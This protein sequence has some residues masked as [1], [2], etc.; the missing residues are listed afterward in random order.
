MAD[1]NDTVVEN[2][3]DKNIV[4]FEF[5]IDEEPVKLSDTLAR[6]RGRIFYKGAN[7]NRSFITEEFANKLLETV[8]YA[9]VKGIY[10]AEN[11]DYTDHGEENCEGRAY[12]VVP[13]E[14]NLKWEQHL[15]KDGV[16]RE[17]ATVDV[18]LWTAI[19]PEANNIVGKS[20]SMELYA[21]S[22][23]GEWIEVEGQKYF[24]FLE[25][26]FLGLQVL[27]DEVEPC[28]EGAGFFTLKQMIDD[29]YTLYNKQEAVRPMPKINFA[30]SDEQ[31]HSVLFDALNAE[32]Y[33]E[34]N[35]WKIRYMICDTY[36]DYCVAFDYQ[37]MKYVRAYYTKDNDN[38]TVTISEIKQVFMV[39]LDEE[40]YACVKR[41]K[42]DKNTYAEA[43][44]EINA[45]LAEKDTKIEEY[46]TANATLTAEKETLTARVT[47][48]EQYAAVA[49]AEKKQGIIE[50]YAAV[51]DED[52]IKKYKDNI[53]QYTVTDLDKE[54]SYELVQSTPS[55]FTKKP[56]DGVIPTGTQLTG[57]EALL[58]KHRTNE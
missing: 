35:G 48:L 40:E 5:T 53:A 7:R 38:E 6:G 27:G 55:I 19:Y 49:D 30:M 41:L 13:L 43:E 3:N 4:S 36:D 44:A 17:Y 11:S 12:G 42:H 31:K 23:K 29:L 52:T 9:P 1:T 18:I 56:D 50:K 25:G 10:D 34:E 45:T 39:D 28:F 46:T 2:D 22:I 24:K 16:I 57:I 21:P 32:T 37:E 33:T 51:L 47:E 26:S 58:A 8:A 14:H 15:D 20:M 54:L